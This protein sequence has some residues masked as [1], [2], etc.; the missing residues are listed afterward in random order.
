MSVYDKPV[1][2]KDG[3]KH[4]QNRPEPNWAKFKFNQPYARGLKRLKEQVLART[5]FD[6]T[7]LWQW[8]TMQAMALITVLKKAEQQFGSEGQQLV[9]DSLREVGYDIGQQ[10]V[11]GIDIDQD[12]PPHEWI[13][14]Y[15]TVINRIVYASLESPQVHGEGEVDFHIDWCPHQ[16][17]YGAFDCRVQRYFV[18]GMIDAALEYAKAQ[19]RDDIWNV[20]FRNTI[21]NGAQT[22][23]F[24]IEKAK[25]GDQERWTRY[26]KALEGKALRAAKKAK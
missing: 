21:P 15:A 2:K 10:V 14:F 13:S 4:W 12:I 26:T 9:L 18:Q 6:P 25:E 20:G 24:Q 8:G 16:D 22:C 3:S 23:Y 1:H 7:T 19:G 17:H 5:N 11:D